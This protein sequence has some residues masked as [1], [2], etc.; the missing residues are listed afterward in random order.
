MPVTLSAQMLDAAFENGSVPHSRTSPAPWRR[1]RLS[2]EVIMRGGAA[3]SDWSG[4]EPS[5][6]EQS[7]IVEWRRG[8]QEKPSG[9]E[10]YCQRQKSLLSCSDGPIW[11]GHGKSKRQ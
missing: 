10:F 1:N 11:Q 8:R 6:L 3:C 2:S 9:D 7:G 4:C 5:G